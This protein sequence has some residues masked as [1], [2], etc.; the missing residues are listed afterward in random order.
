MVIDRLKKVLGYRRPLTRP[1]EPGRHRF[2]FVVGLHRSGT[3][4]IHRLLRQHPQ[5]TGFADT[6][7]REDEGQFLQSVLP[8]GQAFGGVGRFAFD[9]AAHFTADDPRVCDATR[10]RIMREWGAYLDLRKPIIIEKSPPNLLRTT[11]LQQLLPDASFVLIVR[12]PIPVA[13]ASSKW[14][15]TSVHELVLHW[16]VAHRIALGDLPAL[17][18]VMV[19]R[20]E[21]FIAEPTCEFGRVF[22]FLGIERIAPGEAVADHNTPYFDDPRVGD[23]ADPFIFNLDHGIFD[24]FGYSLDAP[25]IDPDWRFDELLLGS[26]K[27]V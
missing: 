25:Y 26:Q 5:I 2:V 10:D 18:R 12:H 9:K 16:A 4:L 7:A 13:L 17:H 20:Y 27:T 1:P 24:R 15:K 21:D 23:L 8:T 14:S 6:P 11:F 22:D 3:S 19:L